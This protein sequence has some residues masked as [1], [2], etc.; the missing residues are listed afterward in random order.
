MSSHEKASRVKYFRRFM[1]G[2]DVAPLLAQVEAIP[3]PWVPDPFWQQKKQGGVLYA[4]NNL[5]LR[6]MS[7]P[8][9][10]RPILNDLPAVRPILFDLMKALGGAILG[11]VVI[12]RLRPGEKIAAHV[13]TW[14]HP[15]PQLYQRHQVPLRAAPGV[16][17][18]CGPERFTMTEEVEMQPGEAWWFDNQAW[19]EVVNDSA[20]DRI[21][22]FCDVAYL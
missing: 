19:H 12:S 11:T 21:S 22:M 16:A 15:V 7:A 2:I 8:G 3:Q 14:P 5:V 4:Q 17:F 9:H 6:F 10:T 18:R 20:E 1:E 13:D